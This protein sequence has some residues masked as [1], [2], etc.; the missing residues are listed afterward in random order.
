MSMRLSCAGLM[1]ALL[2]WS[3]PGQAATAAFAGGCF[4]CMEADY[5]KVEGVS[6]VVSGFMGGTHPN[7]T[8]KGDHDGHYETV[9]V[10]YDPE[11]VSYQQLLDLFWVSIDPFDGDG[12]FCDRG[13]SYRSA[14]FTETEQERTQ[15]EASRKAI[16]QRF[17]D[18]AVATPILSR[19]KFFPVEEYHQDYYTKRPLRYRFYRA[20]CKRDERLD[21]I[22][23]E[24]E[25][26]AP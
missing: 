3:L 17:P 9:L 7:P 26:R 21:A 20:R 2:A 24:G 19:A 11:V 12:Q 14:V 22:W 1:L 10:T 4:W 25:A 5:E 6:G 15:A 23:G 16:A 18:Q 8:Y 13:E